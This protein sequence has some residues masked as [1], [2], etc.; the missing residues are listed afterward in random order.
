MKKLFLSLVAVM[1]LTVAVQ[2]Q[3]DIKAGSVSLEV[4]FL[5]ANNVPIQLDY[6]R[7]RYFLSD[8]MAVRVGLFLN[9]ETF[10]D[11]NTNTATPPVTMSY[12]ASF[13]Q[14]GLMPGIEMH[15]PVGD[16]LS[17]YIGGELGFFMNSSKSELLNPGYING[18]SISTAGYWF[19]DDM[20][21]DYFSKSSF[22]IGLV[23]G[24]DFY[25]YRG[26]FLG[27]ELGLGFESG[28]LKDQST[29]VVTGTTTT[30]EDEK[31]NFSESN[32][33]LNTVNAIRL[34]WKF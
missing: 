23:T 25:I 24:I 29:T 14:F 7:A 28:S 31:F 32:F 26:L 22:R 4:Q 12:K 3:D 1:A 27:V 13:F 5:P 2:A 33:G 17:P 15:F 6:L 19:H 16:R 9:N 8:N 11:E 10:K 20:N 30:T 18:N 21:E 34:G